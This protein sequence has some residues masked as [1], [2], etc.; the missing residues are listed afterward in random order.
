M[1]EVIVSGGSVPGLHGPSVQRLVSVDL[2]ERQSRCIIH[3][4]SQRIT[5]TETVAAIGRNGEVPFR[6]NEARRVGEAVEGGDR[7]RSIHERD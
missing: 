3:F 2:K 1:F 4:P 7:K 5:I 6:G